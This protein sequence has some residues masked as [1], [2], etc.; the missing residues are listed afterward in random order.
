MRLLQKILESNPITLKQEQEP[1]SA[2]QKLESNRRVQLRDMDEGLK[3]NDK[4]KPQPTHKALCSFCGEH[5]LIDWFNQ[6]LCCI[7]C[8]NPV[9]VFTACKITN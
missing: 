9:D 7:K 6:K 3:N 5:N 1:I 4:R 2:W 8:N